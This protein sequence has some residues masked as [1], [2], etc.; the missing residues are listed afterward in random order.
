MNGWSRILPVDKKPDLF[1]AAGLVACSVG[2]IEIVA[3]NIS[4][5]RKFLSM[6]SDVVLVLGGLEGGKVTD[7]IEICRNAR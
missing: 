6:L 2:D 3:N 4:S 5:A 1:T 7:L